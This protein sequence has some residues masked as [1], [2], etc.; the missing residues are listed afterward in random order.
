M[1]PR[2]KHPRDLGAGGWV[3]VQWEED[4]SLR[5]KQPRAVG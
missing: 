4:R 3:Q 2:E 1:S 5:P